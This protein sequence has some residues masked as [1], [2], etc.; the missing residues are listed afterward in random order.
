MNDTN[1]DP[2]KGGSSILSAAPTPQS[3][4]GV[5]LPA[6]G[7]AVRLDGQLHRILAL[8]D[9][10]I[11]ALH[12]ASHAMYVV[13]DA[14]GGVA[15]LDFDHWAEMVRLGRASIV[16]GTTPGETHDDVSK[17]GPAP[18]EKIH[19]ECEMLEAAGVPLG[20]KAM[21]IWLAAHWSPELRARF[22]EHTNVHTLRSWRRFRKR[23]AEIA[24]RAPGSR[25]TV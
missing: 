20:H 6:E 25:E 14:Q 1:D 8:M 11:L 15:L 5:R 23:S 10:R 24:E 22:G 2:A 16:P 9:T 17:G 4:G 18:F 19:T 7:A 21:A 12:V 3:E 13:R